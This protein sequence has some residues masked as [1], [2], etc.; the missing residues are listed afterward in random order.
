MHSTLQF[1]RQFCFFIYISNLVLKKGVLKTFNSQ[2]HSVKNDLSFSQLVVQ[3]TL[4]REG[5][6]TLSF[7]CTSLW[8]NQWALGPLELYSL[9]N[10]VRLDQFASSLP[11]SGIFK[12]PPFALPS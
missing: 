4:I 5:A 9:G 10:M 12:L 7:I 1:Y 3:K 2:T 11:P 6:Q 8:T